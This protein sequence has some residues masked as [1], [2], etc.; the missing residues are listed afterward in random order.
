MH[1]FSVCMMH[2]PRQ[3]FIHFCIIIS[4]D[5]FLSHAYTFFKF[6]SIRPLRTACVGKSLPKG[7]LGLS[8]T[9]KFTT[10]ICERTAVIPRG[11]LST[12]RGTS[13][14]DSQ[15]NTNLLKWGADENTSP[16]YNA[17]NGSSLTPC[18]L[19]M[20]CIMG[21]PPAG[22]AA[23]PGP[24]GCGRTWLIPCC[25]GIGVEVQEDCRVSQRYIATA[26]SLT[27]RISDILWVWRW[28]DS[29]TTDNN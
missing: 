4:I 19:C 26:Y 29:C 7:I 15:Y 17:P 11:I 23:M 16:A 25:D 6:S 21:T 10:P 27:P 24:I 13:G 5:C 9:G 3:S 14:S 8:Y 12:T 2:S 1:T 18:W 22:W 20:G 28:S